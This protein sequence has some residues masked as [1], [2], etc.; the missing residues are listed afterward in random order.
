MKAKSVQRKR[1]RLE[2]QRREREQD[3]E[4]RTHVAI[5]RAR[6]TTAL[7]GEDWPKDPRTDLPVD[8]LG[9]ALANGHITQQEYEAGRLFER[10]QTLVYG[11]PHAKCISMDSGK[12]TNFSRET[13]FDIEAKELL[14]EM[15]KRLRGIKK[16]SIVR[17]MCFYHLWRQRRWG[18]LQQG[19]A[20]IVDVNSK[21]VAA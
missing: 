7:Y 15:T 4:M 1:Q 5:A 3:Q 13:N 19:L 11:K 6:K 18:H 16:L 21:K 20:V 2:Q 14:D 9:Y 8:P 17:D 12:I 10:L